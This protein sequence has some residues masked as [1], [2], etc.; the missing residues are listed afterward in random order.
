MLRKECIRPWIRPHRLQTYWY[1]SKTKITSASWS[2]LWPCEWSD[3]P[4]SKTQSASGTTHKM[5]DEKRYSD[6]RMTAIS[7]SCRVPERP[8]KKSLIRNKP[9]NFFRA[10]HALPQRAYRISSWSL[11]LHGSRQINN[12]TLHVELWVRW[13]DVLTS[14]LASTACKGK[15]SGNLEGLAP[16]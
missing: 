11:R 16:Y 10:G 8:L 13:L 1:A 6:A 2:G 3:C 5:F 14:H 9:W 4:S 15:P 7:S 12:V